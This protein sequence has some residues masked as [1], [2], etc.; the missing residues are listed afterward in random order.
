MRV[1]LYNL[2]PK[3]VNTAMM[4]VSQYHKEQGDS[5][6]IYS[7]LYHNS[8]DKV[9]AFS[10]FDFTPKPYVRDDMIVGGTGFDVSSKLPKEIEVCDYD[11]SL[12]PECDYSI[13]WFS[14]GCIRNCPFCV[15]HDKEGYIHSVTPKNLNPNGNWIRVQDNNFF[16][17]PQWRE[18][19]EQLLEWNQPVDLQGIDV[20]LFIDEQGELLKALKF[21]Y[22]IKIGWD[23]PR[24]NLDDK[25]NHLLEYVHPRAINCY[26]LI[27]FWSTEEEDLYRV[28]HLWDEFKIDPYVLPYDKSDPYQKSFA[29]WVNNKFIFKKTSWEDYEYRHSKNESLDPNHSKKIVDL[30]LNIDGV[31]LKEGESVED[32]VKRVGSVVDTSYP[33]QYDVLY[34]EQYDELKKGSMND[35]G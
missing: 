3:I 34:E 32:L 10:L 28:N 2:E 33:I 7:P 13:V 12:Y 6:E 16:A 20:R 14:R 18:A 1:A 17:N 4:Q 5:V 31:M 8:Y 22:P 15:V 24:E 35:E 26:V 23:N 9:Y 30:H 25:F 29:R 21:H 19:G 27:G 11:W